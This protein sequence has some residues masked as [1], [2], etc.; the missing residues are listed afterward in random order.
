M[1]TARLRFGVSPGQD[2]RPTFVQSKAQDHTRSSSSS[3]S[4]KREASP[5]ARDSSARART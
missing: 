4:R 5:A 3:A 2:G 1:G